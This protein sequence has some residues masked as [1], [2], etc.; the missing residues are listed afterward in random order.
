M[1]CLYMKKKQSK[2]RNCKKK[3]VFNTALWC[4]SDKRLSKKKKKCHNKMIN[5]TVTISITITCF[6]QT[7]N[8]TDGGVY[9]VKFLLMSLFDNH[10]DN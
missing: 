6:E 9:T 2:S 5:M 7:P 3:N 4:K 1:M 10:Q 8:S